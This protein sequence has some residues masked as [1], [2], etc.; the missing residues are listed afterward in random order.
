MVDVLDHGKSIAVSRPDRDGKGR[1][2]GSIFV[3]DCDAVACEAVHLIKSACKKDLTVWQYLKCSYP[4]RLNVPKPGSAGIECG[5][6]QP[7]RLQF[8]KPVRRRGRSRSITDKE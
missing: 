3:D 5:I 6:H 1:I 7:I 8:Y 2:Y 4:A